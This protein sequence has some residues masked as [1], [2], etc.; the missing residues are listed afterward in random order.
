MTSQERHEAR[1]Q[2]RVAKRKA[3][4]IEFHNTLP[5]YDE[6]FTFKNLMEAFYKCREGVRWKASIQ[7]FETSLIKNIAKLHEALQNRTYKSRGFTC[8]RICERGKM[9]DIKSVHISE[10]VV[11][12]CFCDNYLVPLLTHY[13]IYDNGAS[14]KDKGTDFAIDR[15]KLHLQRFYHQNKTNEGYALLFD[16][17]NYFGNI[18]H[19]KLYPII[20]PFI[21]DDDC[22]KLY[23]HFIDNFGDIGLGL[24]SQVSQISAVMFPSKLDYELK[25]AGFKYYERYMD[26]GVI[27]CRDKVELNLAKSIL[28]RVAADLNITLKPTKLRICKISRSFPF[29]KKRIHLTKKGKVIVRLSKKTITKAYRKL[30]KTSKILSYS[31]AIQIQKTKVGAIKR[32]NSHQCIKRLNNLFNELYIKPWLKGGF[33][34]EYGNYSGNKSS[35]R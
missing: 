13:L 8:F 12:R 1:Y 7:G 29:L 21:L 16:F 15:V 11:Q 28:T 32:Y 3:K 27:V 31:K 18:D 24:G 33:N 10:R 17:T 30:R 19:S 20:D 22:K 6:I 9:R 2:R 35:I 26:D 34:Y 25:Q 5:S 14:I 23:H 4:R